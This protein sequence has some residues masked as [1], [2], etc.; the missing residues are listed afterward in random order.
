MSADG[1]HSAD[2]Q[3][4]L[5]GEKLD[6]QAS[7]PVEKVAAA[8]GVLETL[9]ELLPVSMLVK[10]RG[11]R[12]VFVN[13]H[14]AKLYPDG[15]AGVLGKT[16]FDLFDEQL[17]RQY[18]EH[19]QHILSSGQMVRDVSQR[20][21]GDGE[22]YQIE[23]IMGPFRDPAG[24]VVGVVTL[25]WDI[26]DQVQVEEALDLERDLMRALM[27][28]IPD[29][30]YFKDD[31]SRFIRVS[32]SQVEKFRLAGTDDVIGKSDAD[33]FTPEHAQQALAD[34]RHIMETGEPIVAQVEK[35]TWKDRPDTWVS[36]TKMPLRNQEG[37][38]VGTFG[39]SRDVTELKRMESQ[40]IEARDTAEKANQA[41]SDFLA[42][43]SHEIRT[44]MNGILGMTELLLNTKL[45]DEQRQYQLLV[46]S[47]AEALLALLND[48]LD[49]SKIEAGKLEL[50]ILPF[51]LRDTLGSTLHTLAGR[52]A[53]KGIELAVRIL[54]EVPDDLL[55]DAGR[56]RQV[57]VNLVGNAIKFTSEGEIIVKVTPQQVTPDSAT[58]EFAVRDTGIGISPEQQ[59]KIFESFTQADASTTRQYGGTGLGLSI[60]MQLVRMMG[61]QLK[62]ESK[63]GRGSTFHFTA[64]FDRADPQPELPASALA[65]LHRLPVLVVDDNSTNRLICEE[66]LASWGMQATCVDS[67][68]AALEEAQRAAN[69][70]SPYKLALVDVMMPVM[71][72]FDLVSHWRERSE[73]EDLSVIMLTSANRP[74]DRS[75]AMDLGVARC[76]TKPV[77]QSNLLNA[78]T[79]TLGTARVDAN[80]SDSVITRRPEQ[81]VPRRILLAEDGVV[82]RKVAVSLLEKRGHKVTA[83][84]NGQLAVDAVRTGDFDLVLMDVQMPVLDGFAATQAIRELESM[85]GTH[86][87]I[88]AM[89]AHAM[90]GDRQ[91]CLDA[92]MDD[93]VAKPFRPQELFAAVEKV[94]VPEEA[95]AEG[96]TS[97]SMF[98]HSSGLSAFKYEV[99]LEN[100]GGSEEMLREVVELFATECPKQ[101]T[102]IEEAHESGDSERVSRA[103]HTL[104]SSVALL[105]AERA[106]A[107]AKKIEYMARD[108][109]LADFAEAWHEL[110]QRV[111]ELLEALSARVGGD[112]SQ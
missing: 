52:A 83:V 84:E 112:A 12:R 18:A 28:N 37:E 100:V 73:A 80:T 77:T 31:Q 45:T 6:G 20:V 54:P 8:V 108:N 47:S 50:E 97:Q 61:G 71:D 41:K 66:M 95:D 106:A 68:Q 86:L 70:G 32:Q 15:R 109:E 14:Y 57:V 30:V 23:R 79:S 92:G 69:Q 1:F 42:N 96:G 78:I 33:I 81:F 13:E 53:E 105:G 55:G 4:M 26:S 24:E 35:E 76:M 88:I 22:S 111:D 65:T 49:F 21:R 56:L 90:K 104:K 98:A 48:I 94:G 3:A 44:P 75:R 87:P 91:R 51:K 17:A 34:E 64:T 7:V 46:Q 82:N 10:D 107:A 63:V 11:G 110:K 85:V 89:T 16:D 27:D 29:S 9:V 58:L 62:V 36:T 74:E 19:D 60:S 38:I 43:M 2:W 40:L 39:I 25:F 72:G 5:F 102:D 93:Y 103:A 67:G 59:A 99:A 101:M